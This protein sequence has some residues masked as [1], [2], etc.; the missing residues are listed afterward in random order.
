MQFEIILSSAATWWTKTFV[1]RITQKGYI[2]SV[3]Y[4]SLNE[5]THFR[6]R[7]T[8]QE[9]EQQLQRNGMRGEHISGTLTSKKLDPMSE[10]RE[11][12][13]C[14]SSPRFSAPKIPWMDDKRVQDGWITGIE[15]CSCSQNNHCTV[16][17]GF[18][19]GRALGS[20]LMLI[21]GACYVAAVGSDNVETCCP[22]SSKSYGCAH[23]HLSSTY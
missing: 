6:S 22:T 5:M 8:A 1:P 21:G 10:L 11:R 18:T 23:Q 12:W 3:P 16:S 17:I 9:L 2:I 7:N 4:R 13:R 14:F 19:C 20:M 15:K